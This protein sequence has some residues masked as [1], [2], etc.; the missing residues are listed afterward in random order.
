[1]PPTRVLLIGGPSHAGKSMLAASIAE[2]LGWSHVSTDRMARHP[3]RPWS[4]DA[5]GAPEHVAHHYMSLSVGE[6]IEDVMRHYNGMWPGIEGLIRTHLT[7]RSVDCLVLE[8]AAVLPERVANAGL[9]GVVS[10]WLTADGELLESRIHAS[11]D[12]NRSTPEE[13]A[14][15]QKFVQRNHRYNELIVDAVNRHG[16][17]IIEVSATS[18]IDILTERCIEFLEE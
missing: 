12:F 14:L 15:I 13:K 2:K 6:L 17:N 5:G 18:S 9:D 8:G 4:T 7:D 16:L 10:C 11:S 1:M 3:G